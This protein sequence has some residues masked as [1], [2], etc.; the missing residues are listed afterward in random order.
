MNS[1]RTNI[2]PGCSIALA[3]AKSCR[4]PWLNDS[5]ASSEVFKPPI[6]TTLF[7]KPT[8]FNTV[9]RRS[10]ESI[11]DAAMVKLS[12]MVPCRKKVSCDSALRLPRTWLMEIVEISMLS[13]R[14][15]PALASKIRNKT[16]IREL[17]PLKLV[18]SARVINIPEN[19]FH[20]GH[21][22]RH[23]HQG[24]WRN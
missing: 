7:H 13:I 2:L 20:C 1:S 15:E 5:S 23:A 9:S 10:S 11:F 18:S 21:R 22:F 12:L 3:S 6:P 24:Q 17:L 8:R 4:S 14:T 19:T 16:P